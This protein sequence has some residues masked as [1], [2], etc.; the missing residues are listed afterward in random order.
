MA[1]EHEPCKSRGDCYHVQGGRAA[2]RAAAASGQILRISSSESCAKGGRAG[3]PKTIG[4]L[5]A[6]PEIKEWCAAGGRT[7]GRLAVE[8]GSLARARTPETCAAGGRVGGV[9][10]HELYPEMAH[11]NGHEQ[12]L[13]A[14]ASGQLAKLWHDPTR[15]AALSA[16]G[17]RNAENGTLERACA[18]SRHRRGPN[19]PERELY[20][21]LEALAIKFA[22][23]ALIGVGMGVPDVLCG[24]V[25]GELDGGGHNMFRDRAQSDARHDALR[26]ARGY[27]VIRDSD[28]ARLARRIA[29]ELARQG[30]G[31]TK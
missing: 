31:P 26:V 17:R 25:I 14:L 1:I 22:P 11:Q 19:R 29:D 6:R 27:T 8:S 4:I 13:R 18:A 3:G 15:L 9:R 7:A 12:G 24:R 10:V 20:R 5:R 16:A 28:P 23:E 30:R 21:Q 2:G